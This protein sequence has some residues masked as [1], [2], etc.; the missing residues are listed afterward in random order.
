MPISTTP[1]GGFHRE[2]MSLQAKPAHIPHN[3]LREI[4]L[5]IVEQAAGHLRWKVDYPPSQPVGSRFEPHWRPLL[6]KLLSIGGYSHETLPSS[7]VI[8]PLRACELASN[9]FRFSVLLFTKT[10]GFQ[11]L[12][13]F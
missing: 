1:D 9:F 12:P 11:T 6:A 10:S 8:L 7:A 5:R 3:M 2:S 13:F 4:K